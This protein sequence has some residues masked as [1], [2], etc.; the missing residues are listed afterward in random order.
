[1]DRAAFESTTVEP[2]EVAGSV[3]S[4]ASLVKTKIGWA[5]GGKAIAAPIVKRAKDQSLETCV[6][7]CGRLVSI[8]TGWE[9]KAK[10]TA[11]VT[12]KRAGAGNDTAASRRLNETSRI[13][14]KNSARARQQFGRSGPEVTGWD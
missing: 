1:L 12:G 3:S 6:P 8:K 13:E 4:C 2:D 9:N 11:A 10:E 5:S 14:T 7:N